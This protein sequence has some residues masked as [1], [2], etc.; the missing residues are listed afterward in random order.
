MNYQEIYQKKR[1]TPE[2]VA[3]QFKSG[4]LCVSNGQVTEPVKILNALAERALKEDLKNI[5]HYILLPL[6]NQRYLASEMDGHIRH[7]ECCGPS[8]DG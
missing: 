6:R 5:R 3:S 1:M 7:P 8:A 2:E 4:D